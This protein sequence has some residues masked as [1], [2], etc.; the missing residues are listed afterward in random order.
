MAP[1]PRPRATELQEANLKR[2]NRNMKNY[3]LIPAVAITFAACGGGDAGGAGAADAGAVSQPVVARPAA[4]AAP[5]GPM[6]MPDWYG[7]DHTARTV[8]LTVTAGAV[9]DNNYWN[10]NGYINGELAITVPE[11]YTVTIALVNEDPI[12]AHSL[13]ISPE[14]ANFATPP[15]PEPV[16]AGAITEDAQ[17]MIDATMPGETDTIQFVADTAGEY[18]LVCYIAGHTTIGMWLYFNVSGSGK[19]GVQGGL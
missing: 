13:G 2:I 6:T 10:F 12:M 14:L 18:S 5:T 17:S 1:T 16:F 3:L 8:H 9:P 7:V 15:A 4:H 19:A 11:G